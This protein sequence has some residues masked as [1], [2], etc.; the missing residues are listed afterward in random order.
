MFNVFLVLFNYLIDLDELR[1]YVCS[2]LYSTR[3]KLCSWNV[4]KISKQ[5]ENGTLES[6]KEDFEILTGNKRSYDYI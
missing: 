1:Y 4:R 6:F 5:S 3:Y 2:D